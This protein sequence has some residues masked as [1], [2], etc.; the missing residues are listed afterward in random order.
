MSKLFTIDP[1][2]SATG[3][4]LFEN[5]SLIEWG[6]ITEKGDPFDRCSAISKALYY[7]VSYH[8]PDM[9]VSE[10][11]HK[12]GPGMRAKS[13]TILF[14]FCGMLHAYMNHIQVPIRFIEPSVWKGQV[15][16][17]IDHPKIIKKIRNTYGTDVSEVSGDTLDALGIGWWW[18]N[19][20]EPDPEDSL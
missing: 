5:N 18:L 15:S 14:H 4:A 13:I 20:R 2:T 7:L 8:Q 6:H 3:W 1:G 10:Y 9:V 16:K 19:E 12:G 17:K 11:P